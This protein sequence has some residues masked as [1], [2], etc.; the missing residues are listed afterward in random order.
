[1]LNYQEILTNLEAT[2]GWTGN[3]RGGEWTLIL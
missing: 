1:M 3:I 2:A